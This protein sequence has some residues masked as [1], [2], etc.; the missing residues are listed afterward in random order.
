MLHSSDVLL[1]P[2]LVNYCNRRM[3]Y[4]AVFPCPCSTSCIRAYNHNI[5][6]L[7]I[8]YV[9]S[10]QRHNFQIVAWYVKESLD[11]RNVQVKHYHSVNSCS[12]NHVC[13]QLCRY[14]L[15]GLCFLVLPAVA[16]IRNDCCYFIRRGAL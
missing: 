2:S 16:V 5:L 8:C 1:R 6:Q 15:S 7:F 14:R 13:N 9:V 3:Q 11:L 10:K 12:L 4:L